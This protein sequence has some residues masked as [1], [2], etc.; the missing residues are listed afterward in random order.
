MGFSSTV[1]N[2]LSFDFTLIYL[3]KQLPTATHH[4]QLGDVH[5]GQ[6]FVVHVGLR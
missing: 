3:T 2:Q 6:R 1:V 5:E 4:N